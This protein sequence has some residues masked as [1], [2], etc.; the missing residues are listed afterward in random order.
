[1]GRVENRDWDFVF[2]AVGDMVSTCIDKQR[3]RKKRQLTNCRTGAARSFE[4]WSLL[5]CK[6]T[7]R[8]VVARSA[9]VA[10]SS[11]LE[12]EVDTLG[13]PSEAVEGV[14]FSRTGRPSRTPWVA[15]S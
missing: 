10:I 11:L 1:M 7:A 12:L 2:K 9:A 6:T 13:S 15:V 4:Y 3:G 8:E 14:E 5:T